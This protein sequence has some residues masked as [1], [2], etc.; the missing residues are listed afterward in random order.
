MNRFLP[1]LLELTK[2]ENFNLLI[3]GYGNKAIEGKC[4]EV[5]DRDNVKYFGRLSMKEGLEM[6]ANA[7]II[8]TIYCKT[9]P[10]HVF[11]APNKFYE[12]L[13]LGKAILTN[14]GIIVE[15]KVKK[16]NIGFAIEETPESF[17][18]W[19]NKVTKEDVECCGQNAQQLWETTY[20]NY[21]ANFFD[22]TYSKFLK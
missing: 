6:E 7:D 11:A 8:S 14:K 20:K 1:E 5:K 17:K 22:D 19:L 4:E 18:E 16:N 9:T 10:N 2:S 13:S 21:I 12:A 3:A 15:D